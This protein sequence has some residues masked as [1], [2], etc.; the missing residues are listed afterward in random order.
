MYNLIHLEKKT[1]YAWYNFFHKPHF[2]VSN[3]LSLIFIPASP[4]CKIKIIQHL[5][6]I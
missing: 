1:I 5:H 4:K 3:I 2:Q 6:I